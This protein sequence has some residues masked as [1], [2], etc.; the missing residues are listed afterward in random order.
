MRGEILNAVR[1]VL[2]DIEDVDG[3][4][5]FKHIALWNRNV[6]FADQEEPWERP[7]VFLEFGPIEWHHDRASPVERCSMRCT[8]ELSLHLV[9]D[10]RDCEMRGQLPMQMFLCDLL[11]RSLTGLS[12]ET[13]SGMAPVREL[14]NHDHGELL[15][16]VVVMRYM[17]HVSY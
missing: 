9:L 15:E 7:A 4:S 8:P 5:P 16:E 11:M 17:G 3:M 10:A 13:F 2:L 14:S 12:G 6:E 1:N